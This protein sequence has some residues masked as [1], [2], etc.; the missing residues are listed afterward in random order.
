MLVGFAPGG[1]FAAAAFGSAP[2][3]DS[4]AA[5][6]GTVG[7][8][9]SGDWYLGIDLGTGAVKIAAVALDGANRRTA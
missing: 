1:D 7:R 5:G 8:M 3:G 4:A 2:S 6:S 9:T